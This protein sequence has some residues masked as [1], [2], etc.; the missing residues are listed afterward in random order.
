M[1]MAVPQTLSIFINMEKN[2]KLA[3]T[4]LIDINEQDCNLLI[5]L[6]ESDF[7]NNNDNLFDTIN[8]DCIVYID[9]GLFRKI[10][11]N[12]KGEESISCF[13]EANQFFSFSTKDS[14]MSFSEV[15]IQSVGK[16]KMYYISKK[17]LEK[18]S[19]DI[20]EIFEFL[21]KISENFAVLMEKRVCNFMKL[22]ADSK[23]LQFKEMYPE[24]FST[25][26]K[27]HVASYLGISPQHFS[28][29]IKNHN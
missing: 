11:L 15:N 18:L 9:S 27:S 16:S 25:V 10:A 12:K 13:F 22:T 14:E 3:I 2:L 19:I 4:S 5:S 1:P 26:N 24:M 28:R 6:F 23:Y 21:R 17:T 20:K 7:C 8:N 29:L